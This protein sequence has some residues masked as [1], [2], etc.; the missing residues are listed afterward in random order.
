MRLYWLIKAYNKFTPNEK[1]II[2]DSLI[3]KYNECIINSCSFK[4]RRY[5][6]KI[7]K[8][9]NNNKILLI[10]YINARTLQLIKCPRDQA[11]ITKT[12]C[13]PLSKQLCDQTSSDIIKSNIKKTAIDITIGTISGS[14][15]GAVSGSIFPGAGTLI[16]LIAGATSGA[17]GRP[18]SNIISD[19][20]DLGRSTSILGRN[21]PTYKKYKIN[22]IKKTDDFFYPPIPNSIL[23]IDIM[24]KYNYNKILNNT[25][26]PVFISGMVKDKTNTNLNYIIS[27]YK[28][29][30]NNKKL[31]NTIKH[32]IINGSYKLFNFD[33]NESGKYQINVKTDNYTKIDID[34]EFINV[35]DN[36]EFI[37]E[38]NISGLQL[39]RNYTTILEYS[40]LS[41]EES[42]QYAYELFNIV[43][44]E[45]YFNRK[46]LQHV[47]NINP[48]KRDDDYIRALF[49]CSKILDKNLCYGLIE[50]KFCNAVI[51]NNAIMVKHI[52]RMKAIFIVL[53]INPQADI[54][55]IDVVFEQIFYE[56][57][58]IVKSINFTL[59]KR[60]FREHNI[61]KLF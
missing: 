58:N 46:Y 36:E 40:T 8:L 59:S 37:K 42:I 5:I 17:I 6:N 10:N 1:K 14:I 43:I 56:M 32:N 38:D 61:N 45:Y 47:C 24:Y 52:I 16:G 41:I 2:Y 20:F 51:D 15:V 22:L 28:I 27:C 21:I 23:K 3:S 33:V 60:L 53:T 39:I 57:I 26:I 50:V 48:L 35:V 19:A 4:L 31:Y 55:Y 44:D 7:L 25:S 29:N 9:N 13:D 11:D 30:N 54:E 12:I 34:S 49:Y 18:V